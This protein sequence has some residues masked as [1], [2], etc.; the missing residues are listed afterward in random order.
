VAPAAVGTFTPCASA[1]F[2]SILE[3]CL[4]PLHSSNDNHNNSFS[5]K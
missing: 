2:I 5:H 3:L 4:G 1:V